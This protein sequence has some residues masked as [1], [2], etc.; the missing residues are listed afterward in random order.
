MPPKDCSFEVS[1]EKDL[2]NS[3]CEKW[4]TKCWPEESQTTALEIIIWFKRNILT[5]VATIITDDSTTNRQTNK[6][7]SVYSPYFVAGDIII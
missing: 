3:C 1:Y 6:V 5:L 4:H 7:I 2:L